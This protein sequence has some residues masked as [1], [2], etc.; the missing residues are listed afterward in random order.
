MKVLLL[1]PP[2]LL[3]PYINEYDN[4]LLPQSLVCLGAVL[5]ENDFDVRLVDCMPLRIGWGKLESLLRREKPDVVGVSC[6]ESMFSHEALRAIRL[7]KEVDPDVVTIAGGVHFSNYLD[8][9][10]SQPLDFIV[11]WE[12]EYTLLDLLREIEKPNPNFRDVKGIAFLQNGRIVETDPRPLIKNLDELPIPAY[13]LLPLREY[14]KA[15]YLFSPGGIT[16]HHSRGCPANC[17]FCVCWVQMG[18][19]RKLD[20]KL[21][22]YPR[23]RT[24]S[25]ERTVEEIELLV[26]KFKRKFLIFTDD[27]WNVDPKWSEKFADEVMERG[28]DFRWFAFMRADYI[29]RDERLGIFKKL[30]DSGLTHI[31]VG[32]ERCF[33]EDLRLLGKDQVRETTTK[34]FELLRRKYPQVFRQAQFIVGLR[35][36]TVDSMLAQMEYA[37]K[38][39]ADYPS[40][41][42]LT[43]FPGTR[44][45]EMLYS[46]GAV[47][48]GDFREY[49]LA[50]PVI[51]SEFM[52]REE[53]NRWTVWINRKLALRPAW[54]LKGLLSRY[55]NRRRMY[56]W[57]ILVSIK[58]MAGNLL[59]GKNPLS[60]KSVTHYTKLV[61]PKW[62]D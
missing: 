7:A 59:R 12:G 37:K 15:R 4:Y 54:L 57:W 38:I 24:K 45:W 9:L 18:E 33:D 21:V 26:Y 16:I 34:C 46:Q 50:T 56:I 10:R 11:R 5:R 29:L 43:P 22:T 39:G 19:H 62:Y 53:I 2:Q 1:R 61:K 8:D 30:V 17:S 31:S 13:D 40:F 58:L 27:T 3:W 49:D 41:H 52:S 28:L 42:P 55:E 25:V 44:I 6:N 23:W 20:G 36:E 14:G 60:L 32:V 47:E 35:N 48:T 51:S